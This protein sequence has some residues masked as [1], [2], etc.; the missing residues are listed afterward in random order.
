MGKPHNKAVYAIA[1]ALLLT[2]EANKETGD[3]VGSA[4]YDVDIGEMPVPLKLEIK[5]SMHNDKA[6]FALIHVK[7]NLAFMLA[8]GAV[9][10]PLYLFVLDLAK[11]DA[12]SGWFAKHKPASSTVAADLL[13]KAVVGK[14]EEH[15]GKWR[16][17][18]G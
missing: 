16:P 13:G 14:F 1:D 18:K 6:S 12:M 5:S 3:L 7:G 2:I 10:K 8:A 9:G 4:L 17:L 15:N 11:M